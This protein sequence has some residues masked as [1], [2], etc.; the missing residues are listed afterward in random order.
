MADPINGPSN[1]GS[2]I[3]AE[4]GVGEPAAS[5][6]TARPERPARAGGLTR[7]G[8]ARARHAQGRPAIPPTR[9][10]P[11]WARGRLVATALVVVAAVGAGV[12]LRGR[13]T[14]P[15][16]EAPALAPTDQH[17]AAE[18]SAAPAEPAIPVEV[19]TAEPLAESPASDALR[20]TTAP[21]P[22]ADGTSATEIASPTAVPPDVDAAVPEPATA[23]PPDVNAAAV[24]E[25]VDQ[26]ATAEPAAPEPAPPAE[27]A[28]SEPAPPAEPAASEPAPPQPPPPPPPPAPRPPARPRPVTRTYTVQ[29]GDLLKV[30]A[31]R[32]GVSIASILAINDIPNP[33]SLRVGQVLV[34]PS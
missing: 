23:V 17:P 25:P 2:D 9:A 24:P 28:A 12:L 20:G 22:T 18:T 3:E 1:D 14:T 19:R 30:I 8:R 15:P 26:T 34:I 27:A 21:E 33:D 5:G 4:D 13:L 32:Y 7:R 29:P 6:A 31:A 11:Q 10:S 16:A